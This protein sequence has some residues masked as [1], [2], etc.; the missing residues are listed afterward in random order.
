MKRVGDP[1]R[2]FALDGLT[3][4]HLMCRSQG[5]FYFCFCTE[6]NIRE[7]ASGPAMS[8]LLPLN[9]LTSCLT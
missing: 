7:Y 1:R 3:I 8:F 6:E 2:L 9:T 4:E 5:K